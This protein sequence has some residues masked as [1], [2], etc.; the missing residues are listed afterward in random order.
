MDVLVKVAEATWNA[1]YINGRWDYLGEESAEKSR[2]AI[3]AM[4]CNHFLKEARIL[5]VGCGK[6]ALYH[7]LSDKQKTSYVGIDISEVA[8]AHAK[9]RGIN[10][11]VANA[12]TFE[13]EEL[14]D[15][16]IFNEVL[17]YL[18][19]QEILRKY[20]GH[21]ADRGVVIVSMFKIK[22]LTARIG[23]SKIWAACGNMFTEYER[24]KLTTTRNARTLTWD[25]SVFENK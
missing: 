7:F 16:I 6:G 18:D 24:T 3:V 17:Y 14:F 9:S 19:Y 15:V 11:Y 10:A 25:I 21:L 5:D 4:Y 2:C 13:S 12:A 8:V 1:E 23:L 20:R 22:G